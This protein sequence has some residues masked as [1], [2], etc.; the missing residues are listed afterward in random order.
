MKEKHFQQNA[1]LGDQG[2]A[3]AIDLSTRDPSHQISLHSQQPK[4]FRLDEVDS[5][6]NS[7]DIQ[8]NIMPKSATPNP[9]VEFKRPQIFSSSTKVSFTLSPVPA[10]FH[11][12][13]SAVERHDIGK[14]SASTNE[15]QLK[16]SPSDADSNLEA[17][18]NSESD[19]DLA[20]DPNE[21]VCYNETSIE[22]SHAKPPSDQSRESQHGCSKRSKQVASR[23]KRITPLQLL[24]GDRSEERRQENWHFSRDSDGVNLYLRLGAVGFGFGVMIFDGFKMAEPW[25][26]A[27]KDASS[28]YGQLWVPIHFLHFVYV[29]WQTYF[30]FK[31]HQVVFN[32]RK[33]VL[34]FLLCHLAVA[35]LCQWLKTVVDEISV[36]RR[37]ETELTMNHTVE[38]A[39]TELCDAI[40]LLLSQSSNASLMHRPLQS[41][42][43]GNFSVS[44][45]CG[46]NAISSTHSWSFVRCR[47][48]AQH[49]APF[50]FPCAIEY[51]LIA[52]AIFYKMFQKIGHV[53]KESERRESVRLANTLAGRF[54]ECH[55]SHKGLFIG[56]L[57]F[58]ATLVTMCLFF[59]FYVRRE[60]RTT[61]ITLYQS[62]ELLLL[63]LSTITCIV[64][65]FR[66]RVLRL[67]ALS[68]EGAFDD[69]LLLIGLTG[70]IFYDLFLLVP[71]VEAV[72]TG[73]TA[74]K[75]FAAKALLEIVQSVVQKNLLQ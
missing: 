70:M 45:I 5:N 57:L 25:E 68:E 15:F 53:Q 27:M 16:S 67:S 4:S 6:G 47:S 3:V 50:L 31:H 17:N 8:L 43:H 24:F 2:S 56:L 59:I 42:A 34:R 11:N 1:T 72:P 52:G 64:T 60:K 69:N 51:S 75:L 44:S 10:T 54:S 73:Q 41:N 32:V 48:T 71:A 35:N 23:A 61:A 39:V 33:F 13:K 46:N 29:F 36:E 37:Y 14:I 7:V 58:M 18:S 40:K 38:D 62:T 65:T 74:A 49:L 63:A 28:C 9:P 26:V 21:V 66:L 55:R 19:C 20:I 30:L 22:Q 12:G